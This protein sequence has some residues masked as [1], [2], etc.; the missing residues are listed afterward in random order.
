MLRVPRPARRLRVLFTARRAGGGASA[1]R[2]FAFVFGGALI[3]AVPACREEPHAWIATEARRVMPEPNPACTF[4]GPA[5][6]G[7]QLLDIYPALHPSGD[8]LAYSS[9]K[10][11]AFEI[12]ARRLDGSS[13]E[14]LTF[15]GKENVQPAYSP[16]GRAIAYHAKSRG[17]IWLIPAKGGTPRPLTNFGSRPAWSRDGKWI[18]FQSQAL[19]DLAAT[20]VS[21][22]PPST[23]WIVPSSGGPA[24]DV[25]HE[26]EPRG[27]HGTPFFSAD[28]ERLLFVTSEPWLSFAELWSVALDGTG[29]SRLH[30]TS[31]LFDP[32]LSKDGREVFVGGK[33]SGQRYTI[34]RMRLA[35]GAKTLER[36]PEPLLPPG[37]EVLRHLAISR[38]GR[39]L[40]WTRLTSAS[41]LVALPLDSQGLPAGEPRFL[42]Q[43]E[44]RHS[45]PVFSRD[46]K[47]L[48]FGK[49]AP[50]ENQD[51]WMMD[52]DGKNPTR[53]TA[54][55]ESE[56][57]HDW[58]PDNR[59]LLFLSDKTGNYAPGIL[60]VKTRTAKPFPLN[61]TDL[62]VPRLSPD[63]RRVC[64][65]T[66]R[67]GITL[68]TWIL[69]LATGGLKQLT[70][71]R[72]LLGFPCWSPDGRYLALQFQRG[73]DMHV[74]VLP[75]TGGDPVQLT[76]HRGLA[77]PFSWSPDSERVAFAGFRDG[78]WNLYWV[79]KGTSPDGKSHE[80]R[81]LT[82]YRLLN[83]YVRYPAW[84]P[85]GDQIV[86]EYGETTG[87][88]HLLESRRQPKP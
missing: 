88:I 11:G 43:L 71:D 10:S 86:Y 62:G 76:F 56:A 57:V 79:A 17:G 87:T 13:E 38:D 50:G 21:A 85:K 37:P 49:T 14:R 30:A 70:F 12:Y 7:T 66:K 45:W 52:A 64:F 2:S 6:P 47:C 20:S 33:V 26:G 51:V 72:E 48:A 55:P 16:D 8:A 35:R 27:G 4:P 29:L 82:G 25:T 24:R 60:D 53:L 41:A 77:W 31:R 39:R 74:A 28:G 15:D 84:S 3:L 9:A 22:V 75:P 54:E 68:N 44:G 67:G 18:A 61:A 23:I 80:E 81:R 40:L 32:V 73:D 65:H 69:D 58:F 78:A 1:M 63:G 83:A 42:T 36:P 34:L 19:V 59:H 5:S 46:G